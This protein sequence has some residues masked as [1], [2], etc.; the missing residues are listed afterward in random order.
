MNKYKGIKTRRAVAPNKKAPLVTRLGVAEKL[1]ILLTVAL[2]GVVCG[3][4]SVRLGLF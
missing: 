3:K 4:L 1:G 2:L